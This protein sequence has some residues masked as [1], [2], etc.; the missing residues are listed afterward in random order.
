LQDYIA[1]DGRMTGEWRWPAKD[2]GN[3]QCPGQDSNQTPLEYRLSLQPTWHK[4]VKYWKLY[5]TH[6]IK[7]KVNKNTAPVLLGC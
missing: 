5:C 6:T 3:T 2:L 7:I 1:S 4:H